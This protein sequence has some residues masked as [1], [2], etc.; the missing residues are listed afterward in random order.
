MVNLYFNLKY[1][2]TVNH[3]V[4]LKHTFSFTGFLYFHDYMHCRFKTN[5]EHMDLHSKQ[6]GAK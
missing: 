5:N 4:F 1:F 3:G 2:T 6:N